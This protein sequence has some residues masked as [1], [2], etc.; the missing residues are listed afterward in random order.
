MNLKHIEN[1]TVGYRIDACEN[2]LK[3]LRFNEF[4]MPYASNALNPEQLYLNLE[5][6]LESARKQ[7]DS[8]MNSPLDAAAAAA[9]DREAMRNAM[10]LIDEWYR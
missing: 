5:K 2:R 10:N 7:Q 9:F 3:P 4:V 1:K 6:A 8:Q